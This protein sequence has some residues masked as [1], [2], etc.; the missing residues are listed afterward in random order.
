MVSSE[1]DPRRAGTIWVFDL[2]HPAP[3]IKSFI[4]AS[5]TRVGSEASTELGTVMNLASTEVFKRL[6]S[7]RRAYAAR[8]DGKIVS[9]GWVSFREEFVGELNLRLKLMLEEAYIWDCATL[10][11]FRGNHLY[12]AL[13]TH[14]VEELR[15]E[16]FRRIWIGT[17]LDNIA[18]QRGIA[19]AGF[20]HVAD[21][22][23]E[24]VLALRQVW[25]RGCEGVSESLVTEARRVFLN[26]RA[27][28]WL[29]ARTAAKSA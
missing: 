11:A 18:S 1:N 7:G 24:R 10:P 26:D 29:E 2:D 4:D 8:V 9:Y 27:G 28:V 3:L 23:I 14:I 17:D 6:E 13:L 19:H 25:V 20:Q 16:Q 15:V 21:L 12:G 22:V 5:F